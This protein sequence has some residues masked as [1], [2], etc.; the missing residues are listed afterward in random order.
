ME[1]HGTLWIVKEDMLANHNYENTIGE[2]Q[3]LIPKG[4]IIEWRYQCDNHFRTEDDKWFCVNNE[5][6]EKHCLKIAKI[7]ENVCWKNRAKTEEIWRLG[8]FDWVENG[9]EVNDR[10]NKELKSDEKSASF[11]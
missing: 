2:R 3:V 5:V 7:H 1:K 11:K 8:L 9:K 10:I 4:E 6:F